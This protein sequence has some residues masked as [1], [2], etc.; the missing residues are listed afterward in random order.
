M[1]TQALTQPPPTIALARPNQAVK[2]PPRLVSD[3][4]INIFFQEW[5]PLYPVVHRP[6]VLKAYEQF[7]SNLESFQGNAHDMAQL[8]LIFGIAGLASKVRFMV[9]FPVSEF[10]DS[11]PVENKPGSYLLRRE[12]V[13]SPRDAL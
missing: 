4:L 9:D 7:V 13:F 6:T 5:A 11:E 1:P 2:V 12:L 3:Q 8:N 10:A